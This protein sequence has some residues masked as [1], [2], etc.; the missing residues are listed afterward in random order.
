[1]ETWVV[2]GDVALMEDPESDHRLNSVAYWICVGPFTSHL[3]AKEED[4]KLHSLTS[5]LAEARKDSRRLDWLAE[6]QFVDAGYLIING[7]IC[8]GSPFA[9]TSEDGN[10]LRA[11]IDSSAAS[12]DPHSGSLTDDARGSD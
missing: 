12:Q 5:E 6:Q 9:W 8:T 1:M 7:A 11:A 4:D 2:G 3:Q 10:T